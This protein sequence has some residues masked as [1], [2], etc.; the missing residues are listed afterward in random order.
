M[1]DDPENEYFS[2]GMTEEIINALTQLRDLRVAARTSCFAFKGKTPD[3]AEVGA[4]LKVATVLEGSVRKAGS[5]L[6]ITAQ[7]VNVADGYH[8]WS[9]RYDREM[10]D[11]FA[12][13]DEIARAIAGKL[14]VTLVAGV[15][16][17]LVRPPTEN[18]EAY[19]LYLK[20]RFFVN[21]G[22]E[23]PLKGLEYFQQALACD[24][25]YALAHAGIAE[26]YNF[27]GDMGALRPREA[28]PKAREAAIRALELDETLAEAHGAL[29]WCNW[30]H[31]FEWSNAE[32]HF[33][34]A[35]E[36]NPELAEAH[37]KYGFFLSS[38]GRFDE[39]LAELRR[40]EDLDPLAQLGRTHLGQVLAFLGRFPD[41][42]DQ[43]R[44]ALELDPTSWHAN[45]MVGMAYRLN[46]NYPEAIEALQTAMALAGRQPWSLMELAL[47]Y[48]ASGS[49]GQADA[50]Y[51]EL[52]ARSRGEYVPPATLSFVS[53]ELGRED[54]AFEWLERAYDERDAFLTWVK[55]LPHFDP[56]RDDPR[57]DVLL[58]KMGLE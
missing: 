8:L 19:D 27:A 45:Q 37:F 11:V 1:S 40:G 21:M 34:R 26:A 17:Q 51:D 36:L 38:M 12:I 53:A 18:I 5:R 10:E 56:L 52:V 58:E 31:D 42:I 2:D 16:E 43:L 7:L 3:I 41:A 20:G 29:G 30:T 48:A 35:I 13:Q 32:K 54:E 23:G 49:K 9:E 57:F 50:I 4:K 22:G 33:L 24:P 6:R 28:K 44:S 14:Q 15:A 47:T 55:Q 39:S 25:Q 46:S